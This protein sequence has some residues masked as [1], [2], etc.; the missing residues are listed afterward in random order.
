M[1]IYWRWHRWLDFGLAIVFCALSWWLPVWGFPAFFFVDHDIL[2]LSARAWLGAMLTLLGMMSA[3]TAFLFTVIDRP[4]F[5]ILKQSK[6]SNQLWETFS[7][8]ILWL[9]IGVVACGFLSVSDGKISHVSV[10]LGTFIFIINAISIMKFGWIM[11]SI[12]SVR[13]K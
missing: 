11:R 5:L 2:V 1:V 6:S 12:I 8:N 3:T 9:S 7:Q 13:L 10:V 4:D